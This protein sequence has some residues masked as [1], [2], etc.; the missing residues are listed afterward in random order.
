MAS[1]SNLHLPS[2]RPQVLPPT[3]PHGV[4][5]PVP[6]AVPYAAPQPI[7]QDKIT[8]F[9]TLRGRLHQ[10]ESQVERLNSRSSSGFSRAPASNR[11]TIPQSSEPT[12]GEM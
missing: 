8:L 12:I 1:A 6:R 5:Q 7:T 11:A 4:S 2:A 9:L 3:V 10:L